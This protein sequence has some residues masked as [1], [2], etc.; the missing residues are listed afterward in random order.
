MFA[1]LLRATIHG[2]L[3]ACETSSC[4]CYRINWYQNVNFVIYRY[5]RDQM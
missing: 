4:I 5:L 3:S 1:V 2:Y